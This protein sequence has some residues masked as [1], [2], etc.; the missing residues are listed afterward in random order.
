M[1][2]KR[3]FNHKSVGKCNLKVQ[4]CRLIIRCEGMGIICGGSN[5]FRFI[6]TDVT[7]IRNSTGSS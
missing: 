7:R 3:Y 2:E 5:K 1:G 6:R 4:Y